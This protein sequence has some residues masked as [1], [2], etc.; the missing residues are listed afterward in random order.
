MWDPDERGRHEVEEAVLELLFDN[1]L[2]TPQL[3]RLAKVD[4]GEMEWVLKR[5]ERRDIIRHQGRLWFIRTN[6]L[7]RRAISDALSREDYPEDKFGEFLERYAAGR[8]LGLTK[9]EAW[10]LARRGV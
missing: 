6:F 2:T 8:K 5:M 7:I 4:E 1:P 3:A 9:D 10:R